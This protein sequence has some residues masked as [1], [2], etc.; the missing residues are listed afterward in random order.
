MLTN[1]GGDLILTKLVDGNIMDPMFVYEAR[2]HCNASL[3]RRLSLCL[4]VSS[5]F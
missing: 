4:F 2:L 3:L 5:L 1:S